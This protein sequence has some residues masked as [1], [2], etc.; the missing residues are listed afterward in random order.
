MASDEVVAVDEETQGG[1]E[2]ER[3]GKMDRRNCD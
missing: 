1:L 3:E 2:R